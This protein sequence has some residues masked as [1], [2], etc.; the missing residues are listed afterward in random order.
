MLFVK[1]PAV[2]KYF[3]IK[4]LKV[5][6]FSI[7]NTFKLCNMLPLKVTFVAE[8]SQ[9]DGTP[10]SKMYPSNTQPVTIFLAEKEKYRYL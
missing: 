1:F 4:L 10:V 6:K 5:K 8:I 7:S 9:L 2:K 3:P